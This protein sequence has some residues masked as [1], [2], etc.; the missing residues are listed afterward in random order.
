VPWL[1]V[2]LAVG[3]LVLAALH[4][5]RLAASRSA[6]EAVHL[7]MA[8]GMAAM[9]APIDP[10]PA[11]L[12]TA[13]FAACTAGALAA[14]VRSRDAGGEPGHLLAGSAAMLFMVASGHA[15]AG[16]G[17]GP[18]WAAPA[19]LVLA[20]ACAWHALRCTLRLGHGRLPS[21]ARPGAGTSDPPP[22]AALLGPRT[23]AGA[24]AVMAAG[25]GAM[26]L[27]ALS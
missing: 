27:T 20:G 8:L 24:H 7:A 13:V 9:F 5:V 3:C 25:M 16:H 4:A 15:H 12:W 17:T 1:S 19:A 22:R 11:P 6:A 26:L 18:V 10:V 21:P 2:V 14:V 23:G